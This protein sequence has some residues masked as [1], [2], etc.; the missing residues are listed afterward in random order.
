MEE[1]ESF[2]FARYVVLGHHKVC[3]ERDSTLNAIFMH[4]FAFFLVI[5][6]ACL[7]SPLIHAL[8]A[9][10]THFSRFGSLLTM[11]LNEVGVCTGGTIEVVVPLDCSPLD[12]LG[13]R[14]SR[15]GSGKTKPNPRSSSH[16]AH[17][18]ALPVFHALPSLVA[19]PLDQFGNPS[20]SAHAAWLSESSD[21]LKPTI[22][23]A[24]A[25]WLLT[26][27]S[28][29]GGINGKGA[30]AD[31]AALAAATEADTQEAQKLL[32]HTLTLLSAVEL[33][34]DD[35]Q[36]VL[37]LT[38]AV[39]LL[40][41]GGPPAVAAE[42]LGLDACSLES[43]LAEMEE[44]P[45][46]SVSSNH[47]HDKKKHNESKKSGAHPGSLAL[48][49]VLHRTLFDWL[50]GCANAAAAPPDAANFRSGRTVWKELTQMIF[51]ATVCL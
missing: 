21:G 47:F 3:F 1:V 4:R 10:A 12:Q 2:C 22:P 17:A 43:A 39:F 49:R 18:H 13:L 27:S 24:Q 29:H 46:H 30:L 8:F 40:A 36:A 28:L 34:L 14:G 44:Q 38:S 9:A 48:A 25:K 23:Q 15:S 6:G 19:P 16:A 32:E 37:D 33:T 42:L 41:R 35:K 31:P 50:V 45:I 51:C 20:A 5:F 26:S 7:T 11:Y